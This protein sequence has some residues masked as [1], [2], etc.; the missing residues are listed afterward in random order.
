MDWLDVLSAVIVVVAAFALI[1]WLATRS[2]WPRGGWHGPGPGD[3][4]GPDV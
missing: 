1:K 3:G 4:G 2:D